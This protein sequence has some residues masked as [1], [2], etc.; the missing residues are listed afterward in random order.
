MA[1]GTATLLYRAHR[2]Y[3]DYLEHS[4]F[5]EI[6]FFF[7][8]TDADMKSIAY[9]HFT[10]SLGD[11]AK[12]AFDQAGTKGH[13]SARYLLSAYGSKDHPSV[14]RTDST[15]RVDSFAADFAHLGVTITRDFT[16]RSP[17]QVFVTLDLNRGKSSAR[18]QFFM[19]GDIE[20]K[21]L[22]KAGIN[23]SIKL[24]Q[25]GPSKMGDLWRYPEK[26]DPRG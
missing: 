7:A 8:V 3:L 9:Y 16:Y 22:P 14:L 21:Y 17:P 11:K 13:K 19:T 10:Q 20:R 1:K 24:Q 4:T 23:G 26:L 25:S 15:T 2:M 6:E 12:Q 5:T 18:L